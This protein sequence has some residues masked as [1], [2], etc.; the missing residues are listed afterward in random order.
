MRG[1]PYAIMETLRKTKMR[2]T[3]YAIM[4]T[5]RKTKMRSTPYAIMETLRKTKIICT[6]TKLLLYVYQYP[7]IINSSCRRKS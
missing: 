7:A 1:T 4:E 2:S 3:P 6:C 5:L